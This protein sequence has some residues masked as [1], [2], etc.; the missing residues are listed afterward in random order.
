MNDTDR[1]RPT[2]SAFDAPFAA[3]A[4]ITPDTTWQAAVEQW[5][6]AREAPSRLAA[7]LTSDDA[8]AF[9]PLPAEPEA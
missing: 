5:A 4:G 2:L 6:A 7:T 3:R 9:D 8:P 1:A